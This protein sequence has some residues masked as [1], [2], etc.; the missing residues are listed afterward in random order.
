MRLTNLAVVLLCVV[1]QTQAQPCDSGVWVPVTTAGPTPLPA[2][3]VAAFDAARGET[4]YLDWNIA[5][6]PTWTWNGLEWTMRA[7]IPS[8]YPVQAM[9]FDSVR[10]VVVAFDSGGQTWTF[11]G[12]SWTFRL[13][14]GPGARSQ[15][16]LA[17]D[18]IRQRAVLYG[19]SGSAGQSPNTWEWNGAFW[20]H[21]AS[22]GPCPPISHAMA[23]DPTSTRVMM[24]GGRSLSGCSPIQG[25]FSETWLWTGSVWEQTKFGPGPRVFHAMATDTSRGR[26]VLY[27]GS[28]AFNGTPLLRDTWEWDGVWTPIT[29]DGP[30]PRESH[31][32]AYDSLR[33]RVVLIGGATST[34]LADATVWEYVH[35]DSVQILDQPITLT[36]GSGANAMLTVNAAGSG[37]ITYQWRFEGA[38]L[39]DSVHIGGSTTAALSVFGASPADIGHYDVIVSNGCSTVTS[40]PARL[41]VTA[42][43]CLGD[44]DGNGLVEFSDI[45]AVL[46]RWGTMCP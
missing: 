38:P 19:G 2:V 29:Y 24:F 44:T 14:T 3:G 35:L 33:D 12:S 5:M 18:P 37:P 6:A 1:S 27:G 17:F 36:V 42:P 31:A 4:V 30:G 11:D 45:T 9:C 39:T 8:A 43:P 10:Q 32:M 7:L 46:G 22:T 21:R 16:S 20:I 28:S 34:G 26:V 15:V 40:M 23:F 13:A 25:V 41:V